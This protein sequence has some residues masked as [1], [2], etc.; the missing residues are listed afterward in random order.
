[1]PEVHTI[2]AEAYGESG[3]AEEG[4]RLL[5]E[6]L[7]AADHQGM[8]LWEPELYRVKGELLLRQ[9]VPAAP[10]AERCFQPGARQ[11]PP[12][13]GKVTRT[14]SRDKLEPPVA[15]AGEARRG[16]RAAGTDLWLVHRGL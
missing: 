7:A 15:A 3:Q 5:A 9:P 1:M 8:H 4:L 16:V 10:E 6:A 12:P 2:L 14:Q 13:G 11:R